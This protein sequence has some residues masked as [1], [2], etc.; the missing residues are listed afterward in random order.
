ML[1]KAEI[2]P[3]VCNFTTH[4]TAESEDGQSV[5]IEIVSDCE[6]MKQFNTMVKEISPVDA[7]MSLGPDENPILAKAG[8]LLQSKGCCEACVVPA[9]TLKAMQVVTNLALPKDASLKITKE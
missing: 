7:I 3:G 8:E 9:G 5:N 4:V 1:A 2:D 6:T